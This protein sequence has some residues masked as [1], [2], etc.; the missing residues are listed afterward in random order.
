MGI[1]FGSYG[2]APA[3]PNEVQA[4]LE[5]AKLELPLEPLT[6]QWADDEEALQA[7]RDAV[8]DLVEDQGDVREVA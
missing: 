2:W 6:R 4:A 7:V 5:A 1:A 8:I 3:G